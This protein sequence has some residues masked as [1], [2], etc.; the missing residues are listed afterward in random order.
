MQV[1]RFQEELRETLRAEGSIYAAIRETGDITEETEAKLREALD[2]FANT[3]SV[4]EEAGL[5]A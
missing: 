5:V 3:F 2:R 1:P 4:E